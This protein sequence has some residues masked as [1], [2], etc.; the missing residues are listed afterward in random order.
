V[1]AS[2]NGSYTASLTF[3]VV[4]GT[5]SL[6]LTASP[7][8][9]PTFGQ[10][11]VVTAVTTNGNSLATPTGTITF[12]LDGVL[13][14]P[15]A[16]VPSVP[17]TIKL[18]PV[19]ANTIVASYSGDANYAPSSDSITVTVAEAPTSTSLQI[20]PNVSSGGNTITLSATVSPVFEVAPT[21]TVTF[22]SGGNTLG[23]VN[24]ANSQATYTTSTNLLSSY[25]FT[26]SYSGDSNYLGST[27]SVTPQ[28]TF[29]M[30]LS[31]SSL[32]VSQ[33][34]EGITT[35]NLNPFYGYNGTV[36]LSCSGLP[37][38]TACNPTPST[39]IVLIANKIQTIQLQITTNVSPLA[40]QSARLETPSYR[41][42][43]LIAGGFSLS[44]CF[45]FPFWKRRRRFS[46]LVCVFLMLVTALTLSSCTSDTATNALYQSPVGTY[47]VAVT[48]TDGTI[49][50]TSNLSLTVLAGTTAA[51]P[52]VSISSEH[53]K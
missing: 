38:F 21:G 51:R 4:T 46:Q 41:E 23:T 16:F 33:N 14:A 9:I 6:H 53:A 40:M 27:T 19:G 7:A 17:F 45:V 32:S 34:S 48:G 8:G 24:L 10:Q 2:Y 13:Q 22:S 5:S 31:P 43:F 1:L 35:I 25:T 30:S 49:T 37:D 18:L 28:P 52:N 29:V 15:V 26:A 44:L 39:G 3:V 20:A 47:T 42:P 12:T 36:K 11:V 50:S